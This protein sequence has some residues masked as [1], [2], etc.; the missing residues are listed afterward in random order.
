MLAQVA[1]LSEFGHD[2]PGRIYELIFSED[3]W[4]GD[5]HASCEEPM[6][7]PA[8]AAAAAIKHGT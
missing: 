5:V 2:S 1:C 7:T 3:R 6:A 4:V 8:A